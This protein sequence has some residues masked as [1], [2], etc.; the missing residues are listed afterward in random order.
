MKVLL[1]ENLPIDLRH[2]LPG[3][4][5]FTV[6]YMKW[7]GL[8]NGELLRQAAEDGFNVLLSKDSGIAYQQNP[9]RLVISIVLIRA[10][11]NALEDLIPLIPAVLNALSSIEPGVVVRVP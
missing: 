11:T 2:F 7:K 3:H 5:V 10:Q 8:A 6:D 9:K 4:E 1:D